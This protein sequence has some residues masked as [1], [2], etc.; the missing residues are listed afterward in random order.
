MYS[1]EALYNVTGTEKRKNSALEVQEAIR[2][3]LYLN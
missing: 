3:T 2:G 1:L